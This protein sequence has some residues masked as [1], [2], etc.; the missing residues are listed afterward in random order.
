MSADSTKVL[1]IFGYLQEKRFSKALEHLAC[2]YES[3]LATEKAVLEALVQIGWEEDNRTQR[4]EL[5]CAI[6]GEKAEFLKLQG[7]QIRSI[8]RDISQGVTYEESE[9]SSED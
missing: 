4:E 5:L 6:L 1:P 3:N 7:L 2:A 9:E 8:M